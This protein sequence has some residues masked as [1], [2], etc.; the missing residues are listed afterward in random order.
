MLSSGII[1]FFT[2]HSTY[3]R[4]LKSNGDDLLILTNPS[5]I[6]AI[7]D[8]YKANSLGM[9]EIFT[10]ADSRVSQGKESKFLESG[11]VRVAAKSEIPAGKMKKVTLQGKELLIINVNGSFYAIGDRCTHAGGELSQGSLQNNIITCPKHGAKFD[12]TTGKVV[13]PPKVAFFHPKI[14][15][16]TTYQVKVENEN[17]MI[18][19]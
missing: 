3:V 15:D 16:E 12:V 4:Q 2:S 9:S 19:L 5:T 7:Q 18:K 8:I 10:C 11:Y 13:S 17:V 6:I 14:Q 1:A